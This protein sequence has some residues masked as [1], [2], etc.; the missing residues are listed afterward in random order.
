MSMSERA[1]AMSRGK[2]R[3]GWSKPSTWM[4]GRRTRLESASIE[5]VHPLKGMRECTLVI[6]PVAL[7]AETSR[8]ARVCVEGHA[9]SFF[10]CASEVSFF[11]L[12]EN[13][14]RILRRPTPEDTHGSA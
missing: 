12:R 11:S 6:G 9:A 1:Q 8:N 2:M 13:G 7:F 4:T 3:A 14:F 5:I 10:R